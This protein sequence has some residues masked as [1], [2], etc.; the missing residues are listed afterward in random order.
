[1][2]TREKRTTAFNK[3]L[4]VINSCKTH[5]HIVGAF[6]Y[7]DNFRKVFKEDKTANKLRQICSTKRT[8]LR[9]GL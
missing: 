5:D 4:A 9:K 3:A 7:I 8:I 1:M 6:N 2:N